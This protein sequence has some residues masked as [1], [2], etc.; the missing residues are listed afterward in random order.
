M[1]NIVTSIFTLLFF[2]MPLVVSAD[3]L[4]DQMDQMRFGLFREAAAQAGFDSMKPAC[5]VKVSASTVKV[6]EPF[7]LAWGAWGSQDSEF[8]KNNWAP[9]GAAMIAVDAP[10]TYKYQFVFYGAVGVKAVCQAVVSVK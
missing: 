8:N 9:T 1:K 10:G 5:V 7:L 3:A 4:S 2:T 6:H